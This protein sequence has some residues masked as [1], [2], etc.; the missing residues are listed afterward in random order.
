MINLIRAKS[1]CPDKMAAQLWNA[2]NLPEGALRGTVCVERLDE[3]LERDSVP[4]TF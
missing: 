4:Q 2:T 1:G 3:G